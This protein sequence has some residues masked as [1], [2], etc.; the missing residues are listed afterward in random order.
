MASDAK[1]RAAQIGHLGARRDKVSD[2]FS[3]VFF[4]ELVIQ[5]T[6]L[7]KIA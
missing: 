2:H 1:R 5:G 6:R 7:E 3:A 4:N